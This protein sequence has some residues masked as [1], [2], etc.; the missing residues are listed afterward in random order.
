MIFFNIV[1]NDM[2]PYCLK[3]GIV[4]PFLQVKFYLKTI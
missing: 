3:I 2:N 1:K 4:T